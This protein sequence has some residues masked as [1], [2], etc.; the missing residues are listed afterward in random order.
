MG[1]EIKKFDESEV[2][3]ITSVINRGL[4]KKYSWFQGIKFDD[5]RYQINGRFPLFRG[6]ITIDKDF[7]KEQWVKHNGEGFLPNPNKHDMAFWD[8]YGV[9]DGIDFNEDFRALLKLSMGE[10]LIGWSWAGMKIRVKDDNITESKNRLD[11]FDFIGK[12]GLKSFFK[13][14]GL[15]YDDILKANKESELTRKIK[16]KFIED[17]VREL[18]HGFGLTEIDEDPIYYSSNDSEYKEIVYIGLSSVVVE[19]WS[20]DVEEM[21]G[22]FRVP[23]YNLSDEFIDK[24]FDIV[25][26]VYENNV[27][28]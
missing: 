4:K 12:V 7:F 26:M 18:G 9:T 1:K 11:V 14:T 3:F 16:Q 17:T 10:P 24:V 2:K 20:Q 25:V 13:M 5:F 8:I 28:L 23:Y 22:E 6:T 21:T 27:D 19:V 15:S